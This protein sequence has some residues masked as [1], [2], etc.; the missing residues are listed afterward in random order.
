MRSAASKVGDIDGDGEMEIITA[1]LPF[2][3]RNADSDDMGEDGAI[4]AITDCMGTGYST[5]M[6]QNTADTSGNPATV[7]QGWKLEFTDD[8]NMYYN[9]FTTS[10]ADEGPVSL[11][12]VAF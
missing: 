11:A 9:V 4:V 12:S 6:T 3:D 5:R 2:D 8:L 1:G 10:H 7:I